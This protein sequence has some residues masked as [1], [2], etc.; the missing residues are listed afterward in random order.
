MATMITDMICLVF[1]NCE[2]VFSFRFLDKACCTWEK[3]LLEHPHDILAIKL[4]QDGYFHLGQSAKMRDCIARILPHWKTSMPHYGYLLG[5][6]SFGLCETYNY[7]QA[8]ELAKK[9]CD[10][11]IIILFIWS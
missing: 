1:L 11:S 8:E 4:A 7:E 6:Y 9:V 3:I 5:M 10:E 2:I